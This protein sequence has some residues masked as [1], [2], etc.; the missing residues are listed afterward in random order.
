MPRQ[1]DFR[2][3]WVSIGGVRT[4]GH[5]CVLTLGYSRRQRFLVHRHQ[6]QRSWLLAQVGIRQS[7]MHL[8][9]P[10]RIGV[11][12]LSSLSS[13]GGGAETGRVCDAA[14]RGWSGRPPG[15]A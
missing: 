3:L 11:N 8:K 5:F 6:R 10:R 13:I 4:K 7:Q 14:G 1:A 2:E 12:E 15:G 9:S